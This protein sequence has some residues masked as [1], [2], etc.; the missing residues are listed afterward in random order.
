MKTYI[1]LI[2]SAIL[3]FISCKKDESKLINSLTVSNVE[4][5]GC[6]VS[7]EKSGVLASE[8]LTDSLYYGISNSVL[9][10]HI[11]LVYACCGQLKDS[12]VIDDN[13]MRIY[14]KDEYSLSSACYCICLFK[15]N[16]SLINFFQKNVYFKVYLKTNIDNDYSLWKETQFIDG[17]D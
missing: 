2:S 1:L 6:F 5:S 9:S 7:Q 11:D 3:I 17:L 12:V 13:V 10:L 8:L 14:I 16:Y 4:Y 15:Y